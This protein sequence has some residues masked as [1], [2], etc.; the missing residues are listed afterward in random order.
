[1]GTAG[2]APGG[3]RTAAF[4]RLPPGAAQP[5]RRRWLPQHGPRHLPAHPPAG[6]RV[7]GLLGSRLP[8][9]AAARLPGCR[10]R[11]PAGGAP[12]QAPPSGPG[13]VRP[14]RLRASV[15]PLPLPVP[16][17]PGLGVAIPVA[18][19]PGAGLS[20]AAMQAPRPRARACRGRGSPGSGRQLSP[21]P[22]RAVAM[23]QAAPSGRAHVG[24]QP[25]PAGRAISG[26][27][28]GTG[29]QSASLSAE[30]GAHCHGCGALAAAPSGTA[31]RSR[32]GQARAEGIAGIAMPG[33]RTGSRLVGRRRRRPVFGVRCSLGGGSGRCSRAVDGRW[34]LRAPYEGPGPGQLNPLVNDWQSCAPPAM[35]KISLFCSCAQG[36]AQ[37]V[38]GPEGQR[39]RTVCSVVMYPTARA[40]GGAG[41]D[42]FCSGGTRPAQQPVVLG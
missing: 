6:R 23:P 2:G 9:R 12:F 21:R 34:A 40:A 7:G 8:H 29:G 36:P 28:A 5:A 37:T 3:V 22:Q 41:A 19:A 35:S 15:A 25:Q 16:E 39:G 30:Q 42:L 1:M 18:S 26:H 14:H 11:D 27:E 13:R 33:W 38:G 4:P 10:L 31:S 32:S 17:G 20:G 24:Q